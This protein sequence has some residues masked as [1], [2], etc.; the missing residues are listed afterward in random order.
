MGITGT[1]TLSIQ[2]PNQPLLIMC[3]TL[4]HL[5]VNLGGPCAG[6]LAHGGKE[7]VGQSENCDHLVTALYPHLWET[8]T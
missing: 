8:I 1:G 5:Q 2:T 7:S 6:V 4:H 3:N